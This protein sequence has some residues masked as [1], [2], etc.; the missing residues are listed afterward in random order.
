[1]CTCPPPRN[2]SRSNRVDRF[3]NWHLSFILNYTKAFSFLFLHEKN[4]VRHSYIGLLW[5]YAAFHGTFTK[6]HIKSKS[7]CQNMRS[8][9]NFQG[10]KTSKLFRLSMC[11]SLAWNFSMSCTIRVEFRH[12]C[13]RTLPKPNNNGTL[14]VVKRNA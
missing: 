5:L 12:R 1:M 10:P 3:D 8:K 9:C 11:L 13:L 4:S 6:S 7:K 14:S 2:S